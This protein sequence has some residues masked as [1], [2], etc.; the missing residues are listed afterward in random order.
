MR[1]Y[2]IGVIVLCLALSSCFELYAFDFFQPKTSVNQAAPDFTLQD[3]AGKSV[4]L[5]G[6][7]GKGVILFFWA[8]WCPYCRKEISALN[9]EYQNMLASDIKL[10]AVDI[11]ESKERVENFMKKYSINYPMLLDSDSS[12][13]TKY[14]VVGVPTIVLISKEGKILSVSNDLPSNYKELLLR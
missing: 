2:V 7:Q 8:T 4:T 11:G 6:F 10:L 13:A 3:L 14:G 9:G 12:V 1:K 5:S